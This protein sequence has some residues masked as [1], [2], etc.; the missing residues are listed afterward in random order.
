MAPQL[1]WSCLPWLVPG[2]MRPA[3]DRRAK[4]MS[5]RMREANREMPFLREGRRA[6]RELGS[7]KEA[8]RGHRG[9]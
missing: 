1:G 6:G 3:I 9:S 4:T 5:G 7:Y 8:G 2:R